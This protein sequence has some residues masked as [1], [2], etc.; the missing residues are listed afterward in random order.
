MWWSDL[1]YSLRALKG[2]PW[3]ALVVV[4]ILSLGI[5]ANGA[6]FSIVYGV[7][8]DPLDFPEPE[9][10]VQ[11]VGS[12]RGEPKRVH[13]YPNIV[14]LSEM[15]ET[16]EHVSSV[17]FWGATLQIDE[18]RYLRGLSVGSPY[19]D[20]LGV[21]PQ[22]GRFFDLSHDLEGHQDVVVLSDEFWRQHLD[23][24][25]DAVGTLLKIGDI[26]Y[27]VL[28]IAPAG[29]ADPFVEACAFWRATP[30]HWFT[31]ERTG[32]W[33]QVIGRLAEGPPMSSMH[34]SWDVTSGPHSS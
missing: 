16:L 25:P 34:A 28:G 11:V 23:S 29:F 15:A 32:N 18:P 7:L 30:A 12:H 9:A 27:E 31:A 5:G 24:R 14:D 2:A 1:K 26:S 22:S 17:A 3:F 4:F 13:S 8:M 21:E 19:F 6:M 10:I 20:A 33:L